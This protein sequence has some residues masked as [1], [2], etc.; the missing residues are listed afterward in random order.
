ME[1][2]MPEINQITRNHIHHCVKSGQI[3]SS[4]WSSFSRVRTEYGN[5]LQKWIRE[6]TDHKKLRTWT[7]FT[8]SIN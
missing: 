3:G 5:L 7:L 2:N 6:N 1:E 4:F 8:Q